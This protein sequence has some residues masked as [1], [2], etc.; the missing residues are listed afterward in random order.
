MYFRNLY[1]QVYFKDERVGNL[2]VV[3]NNLEAVNILKSK[4]A[5]VIRYN[6][7]NPPGK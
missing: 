7:S 5:T 2:V 1:N 3:A 6:F 4:M